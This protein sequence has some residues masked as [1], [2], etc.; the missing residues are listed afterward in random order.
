MIQQTPAKYVQHI[1]EGYGDICEGYGDICEAMGICV[2]GY[3]CEGYRHVRA[4]GDGDIGEGYRL[5]GYM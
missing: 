1:C 5:R 4:I 2:S 3:I